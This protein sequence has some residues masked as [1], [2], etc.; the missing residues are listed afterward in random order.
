MKISEAVAKRT[1]ELLIQKGITQYRLEQKMA[2]PHNTMTTIMNAKNNSVNL[3]TVMQISRGVG[4]S[5]SEFFNS[6]IFENEELEID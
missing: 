6:P 2:I 5:F 1:R 4:I 3:K